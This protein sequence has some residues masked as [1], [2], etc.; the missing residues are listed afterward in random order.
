MSTRF[1]NAV[2][3]LGL[4]L[5]SA[6][7]WAGSN[8]IKNGS[9]ET[10]PVGDGSYAVY[11]EGQA[12]DKYWSVIGAAGNVAIVSGDFTQ[13]GFTFPAKKGVQWLDLTGTTN[14]PTGV[15]Q[16]IKTKPGVSYTLSFYIG[17]VYNPGGIFGTTSTVDVT[18]DGSQVGAFTN[19]MGNGK[20]AQVWRKFST[21]FTAAGAAT[22]IGFIN[23]DPSDDTNNGLDAVSITPSKEQ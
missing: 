15:Q 16:T 10:P 22:M 3:S 17:N 8:L 18:I 9:F 20:M 12:I 21:K 5:C 23:G 7:A 14:T 4:V 1:Q 13:N 11:S 6:N 19:K 2:M